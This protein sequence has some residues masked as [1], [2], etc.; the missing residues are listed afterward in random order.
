MAAEREAQIGTQ[1]RANHKEPPP[2]LPIGHDSTG[3]MGPADK[4]YLAEQA[5]FDQERHRP[6]TGPA[7]PPDPK[8]L[9]RSLMM[10]TGYSA[11]EYDAAA[12]LLRT[13]ETPTAWD[14]QLGTAAP[15]RNWAQPS[16]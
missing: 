5:M 7:L 16:Q 3:S 15:Q 8:A 4:T 14:K 1:L 9:G 10:Q 6:T 13:A 11:A 12:P 2:Q